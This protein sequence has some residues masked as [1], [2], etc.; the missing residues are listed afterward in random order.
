MDSDGSTWGDRLGARTLNESAHVEGNLVQTGSITGNVHVH[1]VPGAVTPPVPH[2]LPPRSGH[3][4]GRVSEIRQLAD[5]AA[6]VSTLAPVLVVINGPGG[7]GKTALALNG[8][9][10][11]SQAFA[12]GQLYANLR[13][14]G[15]DA[16]LEPGEVLGQFL[17]ALGIP[18]EKIPV[19]LAEQ[20]ALFRTITSRRSILLLLD[21]ATSVGQIRPL[22]PAGGS[23]TVVTS[24]SRLGALV[25]AGGHIINLPPLSQP[26]SLELLGKALGVD[27]VAREPEAAAEL[28]VL[29]HGM[30]IALC[31]AVAR[32][33]SRPERSITKEASELRDEHHRLRVLSVDE[34]LSVQASFDLSYREQPPENRRL[35]RLLSLNPGL[36]FT[37]EVASAAGRLSVPQTEKVMTSLVNANL[38]EDAGDDRYRFNDLIRIHAYEHCQRH[39]RESHRVAALGRII[40]WYLCT[41][42]A[43]D[44]VI[45]PYRPLIEYSNRH[46]RGERPTFDD[47]VGALQWL[48]D[49]RAN[50]MA[51]TRSAHYNGMAET[52]WQLCDALWSFFLYRRHYRDRLEIDGIGVQSA[53]AWGNR[54]AEADMLK[55]QGRLFGLMGKFPEAIE[56]LWE[57]TTVNR[58]IGN[59]RGEADSLADLGRVHLDRGETSVAAQYLRQA[60]R[61]HRERGDG[62]DVA[63]TLINLGLVS[64]D[65]GDH[66]RALRELQE[67]RTMIERHVDADPYNYARALIALGKV[68]V[69]IG[70]PERAHGHL[71]KGLELMQRFGSEYRLA[72]VWGLLGQIAEASGEISKAEK[73]YKEALRIYV[74][75][76]AQ[77]ARMIEGRLQR[78]ELRKGTG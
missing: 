37:I 69:H 18:P 62:R 29:C 38:I 7:V 53:R 14:Y 8:L 33:G 55:R 64:L 56:R 24:R 78:L 77:E 26:E 36:D 27:R 46:G 15:T 28:A 74:A 41:A 73:H 65:A 2:Q 17:R 42:R 4:V 76:G 67:A 34:T 22:L 11:L 20:E 9:H 59:L 44:R 40:E 25:A 19:E 3:F 5:F 60:L 23:L 57:A 13:P 63:L 61:I 6:H 72:E 10:L 31:G 30:P 49:E 45:T 39:T 16:N 75:L 50:L 70:H 51:V 68:N 66:E 32:L 54:V 58:S 48:D 12:D 47:R 71:T 35:Y 1:H 43:A 52:A 21:N